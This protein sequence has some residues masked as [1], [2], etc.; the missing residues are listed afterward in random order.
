MN[1]EVKVHLLPVLFEPQDVRDG[2]AV[3]IDVL[4]ASTTIVHALA[5]GASCV[6]PCGEVDEAMGIAQT[7]PPGT[8]LLGGEREGVL[9][10]GFQ[11]DNNP[12]AYSPEVVRGKTIV[13]TTSNGTRALLRAIQANRILIG[14]F[15]NLQAIVNV[16]AADSR[17]VHLVCAGTKGKITVEDCLCAGAIVDGLLTATSSSE[18]EWTDDQLRLALD[19]YRRESVT[20]ETFRQ[21]M[22]S[23]YG[24]RNCV[25]LGYDEQID[26]AGTTDLFHVVPEYN[27]GSKSITLLQ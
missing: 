22:R 18:L 1:R 8:A 7:F 2:I 15:V 13:F 14:S 19:L 6:I 9:I 4:R 17:P 27:S 20:P 3:I 25:R 26:R 21:A 12:F 10:D 23:G 11:L 24:G 5:N 16:L